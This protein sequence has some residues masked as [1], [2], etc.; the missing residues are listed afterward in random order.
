MTVNDVCDKI[1]GYNDG[2]VC[3][4]HECDGGGYDESDVFFPVDISSVDQYI[5][6]PLTYREVMNRDV[7]KLHVDE[8]NKCLEIWI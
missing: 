5:A 3:I 8:L 6:Y 7:K 4:C 2:S 1:Y